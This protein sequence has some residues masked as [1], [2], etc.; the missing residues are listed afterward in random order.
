MLGAIRSVSDNFKVPSP[1]AIAAQETA[2]QLLLYCGNHPYPSLFCTFSRK[3]IS[4]LELCFTKKKSFKREKEDMWGTYHQHRSSADFHQK[5]VQFVQQAIDKTPS[6]A[7][8]QHVT[9]EV[10]KSIIKLKYPIQE[11]N[12]DVSGTHLTREEENALRYVAGHVIRKIRNNLEHSSDSSKDDMILCIMEM[13]GD[14]WDEERGTEDWTNAIDRGGLWHISDQAYGLFYAIEEE[15]RTHFKPAAASKLC[16]E[17]CQSPSVASAV[18]NNEDVLFHWCMLAA[19]TDDADANKLLKMIVELY[20]TIRGFSF[21]TSCVEL[22]KRSNK[23]VLQKGKGLRK[24]LFT[25]GVK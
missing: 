13:Y 25:S 8:Y 21:A 12:S 3:L 6:P 20:V 16:E 11:S 10:F 17:K 23:K 7:F 15:V 14:E 4:E 19:G 24:E 5:W 18:L 1:I 9:H 22:Y 2:S